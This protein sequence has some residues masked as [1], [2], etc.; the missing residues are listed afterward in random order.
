MKLRVSL[1][2]VSLCTLALLLSACAY[3]VKFRPG[4]TPAL[5]GTRS[6]LK[7][8]LVL[9]P[10]VKNRVDSAKPRSPSVYDSMR[11]YNFRVGEALAPLIQKA[12]EE[13]FQKVQEVSTIPA[14]EALGQMGLDGTL[15]VKLVST[16][17]DIEVQAGAFSS[18]ARTNYEI[19]LQAIFLDRQG[20][21]IFSTNA[22]GIGFSAES[23]G[24]ASQGEKEFSVGVEK[25]LREVSGN[26]VQQVVTS[27][28]VIRYG[29]GL[30]RPVVR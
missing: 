11:T 28:P 3:E 4:L 29:E 30:Q 12:A 1:F 13:T 27:A 24:W 26:V 18:T 9:D 16:N 20:R 5:A 6:S 23:V 2:V 19:T 15:Q 8:A 10:E 17:V 7:V 21:Q 25:A 14:A 22:R